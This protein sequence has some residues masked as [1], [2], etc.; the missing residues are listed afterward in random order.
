MD[1]NHECRDFFSWSRSWR[2]FE[3]SAVDAG[4][5]RTGRREEKRRENGFGN[6]GAVFSRACE[7][8]NNGFAMIDGG[9]EAQ[10]F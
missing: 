1:S 7:T 2:E 3:A 4:S 9:R 10:P 6:E 8:R 5:D